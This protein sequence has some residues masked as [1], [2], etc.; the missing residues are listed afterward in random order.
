MFKFEHKDGEA[1]FLLVDVG[2]A[3]VVIEFLGVSNVSDCFR[4]AGRDD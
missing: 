4:Y 2:V 1:L 3:R